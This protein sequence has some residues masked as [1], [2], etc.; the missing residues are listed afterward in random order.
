MKVPQIPTDLT[1]DNEQIQRAALLSLTLFQ[2][3]VLISQT[4]IEKTSQ[5]S[6]FNANLKLGTSSPKKDSLNE[7]GDI[8][9]CTNPGKA[10]Q[11][12]IHQPLICLKEHFLASGDKEIEVTAKRPIII[13]FNHQVIEKILMICQTT[14]C[15]NIDGSAKPPNIA[16]E[17]SAYKIR[18]LQ[19]SF[20]G[21]KRVSVSIGSVDILNE[22]PFAKYS[23]RTSIDSAKLNIA[24]SERPQCLRFDGAV[25]SIMLRAGLGVVLHP[26]SLKA[27][28][29][30]TNYSWSRIPVLEVDVRSGCLDICVG[31]DNLRNLDVAQKLF[32]A[33]GEALVKGLTLGTTTNSVI[34]ISGEEKM[35]ETELVCIETPSTQNAA[36]NLST[37]DDGEYYQDDLRFVIL[38]CSS[39]LQR[40]NIS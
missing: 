31:P 23:L 9:F 5:F 32:A 29:K 14:E 1:D 38:L 35:R 10:N 36:H 16:I 13:Q 17:K 24:F 8:I 3:N 30:L 25:Q 40:L 27:A 11:F 19:K 37:D 28:G 33:S 4:N 21:A 15:F 2:P 20:L 39:I 7:F 12:G 22:C 26:L 6:L 18:T 34:G